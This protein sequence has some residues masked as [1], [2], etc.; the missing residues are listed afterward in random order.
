MLDEELIGFSGIAEWLPSEL[1]SCGA[2]P[3]VGIAS[4]VVPSS[5]L[6]LLPILDNNAQVLVT[7]DPRNDV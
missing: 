6:K 5:L 1:Y 7:P 4:L 3:N 2:T